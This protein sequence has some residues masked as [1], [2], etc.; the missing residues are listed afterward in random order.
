MNNITKNI[1]GNNKEVKVET[2]T[3]KDQESFSG[4]HS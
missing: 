2:D 3:H 4:L 1:K